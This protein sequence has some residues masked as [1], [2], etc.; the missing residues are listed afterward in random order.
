MN[1]LVCVSIKQVQ[2]E[3]A[4][5]LCL[6]S[7]CLG[8]GSSS[9]CVNFNTMLRRYKVG[10][11]LQIKA[12]IGLSHALMDSHVLHCGST[13]SIAPCSTKGAYEMT[14]G[15]LGFWH[16][17]AWQ[18]RRT[19]RRQATHPDPVVAASLSSA[20]TGVSH[21]QVYAGNH[22]FALFAHH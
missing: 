1:T 22:C 11:M 17:S 5:A 18:I 2:G 16:T 10:V 9:V 3:S 6:V 13:G 12:C 21:L 14:A 4:A 8:S 20:I 7:M 19:H 15:W